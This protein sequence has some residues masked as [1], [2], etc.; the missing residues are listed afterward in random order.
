MEEGDACFDILCI[1]MKYIYRNMSDNVFFCS[2]NYVSDQ[3]M[4]DWYAIHFTQVG[5][6][7]VSQEGIILGE[8][9]AVLLQNALYT[10]MH[11]C[12]Y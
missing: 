11:L 7:L 9:E 5:A 3:I 12:M 4:N 2:F 8:D 1:L 10:A 6:C